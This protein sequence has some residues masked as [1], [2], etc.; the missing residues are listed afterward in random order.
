VASD[1]HEGDPQEPRLGRA[2]VIGY[3]VG[4]VVTTAAVTVAGTLGGMGFAPSL[5]LGAFVGV[6]G[7]G[8]FGFMLGGTVPFALHLD[9][10]E[11][12]AR[13]EHPPV[14]APAERRAA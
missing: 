7:G 13:A 14:P 9:R 12:A 10:L 4:F 6:W 3:V 1:A 2:G 5:G 8:G 11:A